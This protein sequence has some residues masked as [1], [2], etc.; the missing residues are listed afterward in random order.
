MD[1]R[2]SCCVYAMNS[3]N[4]TILFPFGVAPVLVDICFIY[5]GHRARDLRETRMYILLTL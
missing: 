1:G 4:S 2:A 5:H 3:G